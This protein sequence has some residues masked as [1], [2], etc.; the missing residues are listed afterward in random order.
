MGPG[1]ALG[2]RS[3]TR[4]REEI[5]NQ[6]AINIILSLLKYPMYYINM[7]V[8]SKVIVYIRSPIAYVIYIYVYVYIIHV[9]LDG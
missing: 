3:G 2:T 1:P 6:K 5:G 8:N 9:M 7:N 4:A